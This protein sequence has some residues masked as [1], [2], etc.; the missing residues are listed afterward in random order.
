[1]KVKK[2]EVRFIRGK[3]AE[4]FVIASVLGLGACAPDQ[5]PTPASVVA[6]DPVPRVLSPAR[7]DEELAT[8]TAALGPLIVRAG[9]ETHEASIKPWSAWWYPI[10]DTA[11]FEGNKPGDSPL[12]KYDLY[13]K[14]VRHEEGGAAAFERENLYD[15]RASGWE[16]HCNAWSLASVMEP[17]PQA[18]VTYSGVTFG[19]GDQKALLI[20][21]YESV[22]GIRQFGQRYNGDRYSIYDDIFPDQLHRVIQDQ[23]IGKG[24]PFIID[25]EPGVAVWNFPIWKADIAIRPDGADA[26]RA[27]V[28][29]WLHGASPFVSEADFKGTLPLAFRYTYDLIGEPVD[30]PEG[31]SLRVLWGEWTGES[32]DYHPDFVT[33]LPDGREHGSRNEKIRNEIVYEIIS[34]RRA[35]VTPRP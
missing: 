35:R 28:T 1:M 17:E 16:G 10:R 24:R 22:Q 31:R 13:V 27:H 14:N 7:R 34:G 33:V 25:K 12:E 8:A 9:S 4:S 23:L 18:A 5:G 11:L 3:A 20:K 6:A 30:L 32:R 19:V 15:S 21:S 2:R 26:G 29:L